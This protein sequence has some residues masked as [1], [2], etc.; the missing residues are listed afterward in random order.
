[1]SEKNYEVYEFLVVFK[2]ISSLW[3]IDT[4]FSEPLTSLTR[5]NNLLQWYK[6]YGHCITKEDYMDVYRYCF[7]VQS[8]SSMED[9]FDF[10]E[11]VYERIQQKIN[12]SNQNPN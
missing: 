8:F 11:E 5:V 1:M 12:H 6:K 10:Q 3:I 9:L 4:C 7:D 2:D